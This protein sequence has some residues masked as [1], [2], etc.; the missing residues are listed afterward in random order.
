MFREPSARYP[1]KGC[2]E[3]KHMEKQI[4]PPPAAVWEGKMSACAV[5]TLDCAALGNHHLALLAQPPNM[6]SS[7]TV[8]LVPRAD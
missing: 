4:F 1:G 5:S 6:G 7:D 3:H 8:E 2:N